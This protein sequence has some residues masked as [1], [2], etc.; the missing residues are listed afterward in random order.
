MISIFEAAKLRAD[1]DAMLNRLEHTL[2]RPGPEYG[3]VENA[4]DVELARQ[5]YIHVWPQLSHREQ[6]HYQQRIIDLKA[7]SRRRAGG[8]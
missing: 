3:I 8:V 6:Q 1:M 4:A 2:S 7:L 5:F